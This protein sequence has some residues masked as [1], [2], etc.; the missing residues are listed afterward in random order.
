[1][2]YETTVYGLNKWYKQ[3]LAMFG[4][5]IASNNAEHQKERALRTYIQMEHLI[6]AIDERI[7]NQINSTNETDLN[8]MKT[9]VKNIMK[10]MRKEFNIDDDKINKLKTVM[11]EIVA[12]MT[13]VK[14]MNVN[15]NKNKN[16][17]M[18]VV[19][20]EEVEMTS[21]NNANKKSNNANKKSNNGNMNT[22][23]NKNN[24]NKNNENKNNENKNNEN[25]NNQNGGKKNNNK[26][27]NNKKK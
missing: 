17:N 6:N 8:N 24:E 5:L 2:V 13:S 10:H 18:N 7:S 19:V 23:A 4:S 11:Q 25:K 16:K 1:M 12:D 15:I 22:N 20:E 3:I 26:K 14:N 27:N 21:N 9:H